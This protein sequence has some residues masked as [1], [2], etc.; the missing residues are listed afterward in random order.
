MIPGVIMT[1][2]A[3]VSAAPLNATCCR[4]CVA[5][6]QAPQH[7]GTSPLKQS[8]AAG[9]SLVGKEACEVMAMQIDTH[10][11]TDK[12]TNRKTDGG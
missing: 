6:A 11:Q 9:V 12:Q 1:V 3:F 10:T 8:V 2:L 5:A 7:P 4:R